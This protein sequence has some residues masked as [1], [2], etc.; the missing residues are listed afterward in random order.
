VPP[1][2]LVSIPTHPEGQ[3]QHPCDPRTSLSLMFQ[4]PPTPKG[5]CNPLPAASPPATLSFNP[6]P[7]RRAGATCNLHLSHAPMHVSIPTHPEG[8]VQRA[9]SGGREP[10]RGVSIPTHPEGQVQR[11]MGTGQDE[12]TTVSIPTHPEGQVQQIETLRALNIIKGFNPHPPR[13][14]GATIQALCKTNGD[15][16]FQSPPTPKGRCNDGL[17]RLFRVGWEVSIPTHPEGQVQ[18]PTAYLLAALSPVSIPT[19]PEGQVQPV[20][21]RRCARLAPGFNPHPPRR[22]G[23]TWARG[24]SPPV[25]LR[26]QS[27]PTPKGRCNVWLQQLA[28]T[29]CQ[30]QS[31]PTPKG[32]C[33]LGCVLDKR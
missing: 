14:A 32:R 15:F 8:Q 9:G 10:L 31:P 30:F 11:K 13:R 6:H 33:N 26:F 4:S 19:H 22:A 1:W 28:L 27:P 21:C 18:H 16:M 29:D 20:W 17:Q 5:R 24:S 7:P 23:A 2:E 25:K 3:V 12:P